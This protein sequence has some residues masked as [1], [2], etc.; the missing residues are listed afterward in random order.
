[1]GPPP[2]EETGA[3]N[4]ITET[5]ARFRWVFAGL[6]GAKGKESHLAQK[7]GKKQET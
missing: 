2:I 7:I 5:V 4:I 6:G 1:M 3:V